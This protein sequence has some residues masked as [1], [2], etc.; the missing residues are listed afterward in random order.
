ML[1]FLGQT[2]YQL[3][4]PIYEQL[5]MQP[6]PFNTHTHYIIHTHGTH[7]HTT[8]Y[9]HTHTLYDKDTHYM[10]HTF[11]DPHTLHVTHTRARTLHTHTWQWYTHF[12]MHT[13]IIIIITHKPTRM[14]HAHCTRHILHDAHTLLHARLTWSESACAGGGRRSCLSFPPHQWTA[15]AWG[16]PE[17]WTPQPFGSTH[18]KRK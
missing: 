15:A 5:E 9:T 4:H 10:I 1:A 18:T 3:S 8:W 14:V 13:H 16:Q 17:Q 11:C 2:L 12:M 7:T 6:L